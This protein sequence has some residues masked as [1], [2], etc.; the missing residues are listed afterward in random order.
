MPYSHPKG[1]PQYINKLN[2]IKILNLIRETGRVSRADAAKSSGISAPTVT[3]IVDSLI[4]EGLV[5]EVGAGESSGGRRPTLLEFS[6]LNNFVIGI[7]LGTTHINAVLANMNAESVS[8]IQTDTNIDEGFDR[9]MDR[10]GD[11]ICDLRN[12]PSVKGEKIYGV[13]IA[14]AGLVNRNKNIVEFSPDFHWHDANIVERL[15]KK[16]DLTIAFD[17][18]TRVMALGELWYG[19]GSKIKN[20]IVVN[21]GYGIGAGIIINGKPL[22]GPTGMAGEFGHITMNKDSD[23]QCECGNFGCL[24]AL[25]SGRAIALAAKKALQTGSVSVLKDM[26]GGKVEHVTTEMVAAAAKKGDLLAK[27]IFDSAAN[28]IGIGI[29]GLITLLNPEAVLIG[30]GVA[31]AGDILFDTIKKTVN[32]RTMS[33]LSKGLILQPVTNGLKAAAMGSVALILH[34]VLQLKKDLFAKIETTDLT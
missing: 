22:Y 12:H 1:S 25:S 16:C 30:G 2:K 10:V 17:N 14:V 23:I 7:D 29:S 26:C 33:T 31:Q 28:Y 3:R 24:E 6:G 4:H 18:V 5:H 9:I 15:S 11:V 19:I 8:E 21:I 34:D 27:E 20:F 13:G 32:N